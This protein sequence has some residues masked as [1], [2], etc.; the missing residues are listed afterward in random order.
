MTK[1]HIRTEA[2]QAA[3]ATEVFNDSQAGAY[4]GGVA[5]RLLRLWRRT[6]G[7]PHLK[8]TAKVIRYRKSDLDGWLAQHR[9]QV[10]GR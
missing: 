9:V 7:L 8:L 6:R 5:P 2:V 1:T 3:V 10:G 4:L